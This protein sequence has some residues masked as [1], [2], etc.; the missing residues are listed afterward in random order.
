MSATSSRSY[1]SVAYDLRPAKQVE[2]RMLLDFFRRLSGTG[3]PV[4]SFRYTGMGSIH[5]VDH[6]LFHKFLGIDKL[7]SVERD[8]D[9]ETRIRFNAPFDNIEIAIMGIGEYIPRLRSCEKHIVWLDYDYQLTD[10][11]IS[12]VRSC[13]ALL[14]VGSFVL[15]TVDVEQHKTSTGASDNFDYYKK[16]ATNLWVPSWKAIDFSKP[17]LHLRARDLIAQAFREGASGRPAVELLPC[18]SFLYSDG[19]RMMT[20]GVQIGHRGEAN[21]LQGLRDGGAD[22][23]VLGFD[24]EPFHIEVPVLTRRERPILEST[25]PSGNFQRVK[26]VGVSKEDFGKFHKIYRFL[27]S[28]GELMLG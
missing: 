8:E 5:F 7:V 23:L 19:H 4:E 3:I 14:P 13:A 22:Y 12:D 21:E 1:L 26:H 10:D 28:Y 11:M 6:I 24:D 25:M 20:F 15:V 2:R 17:K 9:I 27:P 16:V 18:F